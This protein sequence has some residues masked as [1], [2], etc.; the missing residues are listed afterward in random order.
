MS[1]IRVMPNA[2]DINPLDALLKHVTSAARRG[3]HIDDSAVG[4]LADDIDAIVHEFSELPGHALQVPKPVLVALLAHA[5]SAARIVGHL[6]GRDG[7][8]AVERLADHIDAIVHGLS[9]LLGDPHL[10]A[11]PAPA[12][13]ATTQPATMLLAS[14]GAP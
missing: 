7:S 6:D 12:D 1:D 3:G 9:E 10:I 4:R 14:G 2:L 13:D 11:Q 5:S 8:P